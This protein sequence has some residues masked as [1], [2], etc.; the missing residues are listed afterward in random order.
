MTLTGFGG[1]GH[2]PD[3]SSILQLRDQPWYYMRPSCPL[4]PCINLPVMSCA[5]FLSLLLCSLSILNVV[6]SNV[7]RFRVCMS[8]RVSGLEVHNSTV[9]RPESHNFV[10][11]EIGSGLWNWP[12]T[13]VTG[14][15]MGLLHKE[16]KRFSGSLGVCFCKGAKLRPYILGKSWKSWA[17]C[18]WIEWIVHIILSFSCV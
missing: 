10:G 4:W 1:F 8:S 3:W 14:T 11:T 13:I 12:L 18:R 15:W 16:F 6:V 9:C 2:K 5:A 17:L 7:G